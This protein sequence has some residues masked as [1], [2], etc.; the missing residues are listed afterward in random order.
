MPLVISSTTES[1]A[2]PSLSSNGRM[3]RRAALFA[4]KAVHTAI[5][6]SLAGAVLY[7]FYCG[8]TGRTTRTTGVAVAAVLGETVVYAGNGFRCPLTKVAEGL[9]AENGTVGDIFLPAWFARRLPWISSA[10]MGIGLLGML[11]R[12]GGNAVNDRSHARWLLWA[13]IR[14]RMQCM[15]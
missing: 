12:R 7:T 13:L 11:P 10:I 15:G 2:A 14:P 4:V 1:A 8:L 6:A 3:E 5:F 9:G